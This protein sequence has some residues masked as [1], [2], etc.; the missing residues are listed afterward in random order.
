VSILFTPAAIGRLEIKNR[1]V[2]SA[3]NDRMVA[4]DGS[5]T[6]EILDYYGS[7]VRGE[8]GLIIT[9]HA[10][11]HP[12]GRGSARQLAAYDDRF[13]PGLKRMADTVHDLGGRIAVQISHAG[14]Q[15][16]EEMIGATPLAPSAL[17][18]G[19]QKV[20]P[21]ELSGEEVEE[22]VEL[23]VKAGARVKAAGFDAVQLHGAHGYLIG[24]FLSPASNVRTDGWGGS[25]ENRFRFLS[26]ILTRVKRELGVGFPVFIKLGMED[27][28]EGG[29]TLPE[30]IS[31]ARRLDAL[32]IDAVETSGGFSGKMENIR[33]GILPHAGEAYF[34]HYASALKKNVDVPVIL[35]GGLRSLGV[36]EDIVESGDADFVSLSRPFIREP[37]LVSRLRRGAPTVSCSSCSKCSLSRKPELK[38]IELEEGKTSSA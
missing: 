22:I 3:T 16:R 11:V 17:P 23:F 10:Y 33:K 5:V 21:H 15:T 29:L 18:Y 7:L 26:E 8:V 24:Q 38:C 6:D 36:M 37:D 35:V 28:V 14:R 4:D 13:I 19:L 32:G 25:E 2:R 27:F 9:G 30:S 1:F 20:I 12:V 31:I 34:R